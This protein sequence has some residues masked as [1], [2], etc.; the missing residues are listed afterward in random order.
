MK[1]NK[2]TGYPQR[3]RLCDTLTFMRRFATDGPIMP[4]PPTFAERRPLPDGAVDFAAMV[5]HRFTYATI[6]AAL[7]V[8]GDTLKRALRKQGVRVSC[9][10]VAASQDDINACTDEWRKYVAE[11]YQKK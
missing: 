2:T 9:K 11:N 7:D 5:A 10:G 3:E 4:I 6:G 1:R 8:N